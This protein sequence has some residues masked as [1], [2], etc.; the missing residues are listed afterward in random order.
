MILHSL[1]MYYS[2][3]ATFPSVFWRRDWGQ[4]LLAHIPLNFT[5]NSFTIVYSI[6]SGIVLLSDQSSDEETEF[7]LFYQFPARAP[8]QLLT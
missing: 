3:D 7:I 5:Y 2:L 1:Y 4:Y 6:L 8:E